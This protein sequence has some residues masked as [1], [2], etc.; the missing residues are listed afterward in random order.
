MVTK[1][2]PFLQ[3][4]HTLSHTHFIIIVITTQIKVID[5]ERLQISQV[6]S[7]DWVHYFMTML[8]P[9]LL[10]FQSSSSFILWP[11]KGLNAFPCVYQGLDICVYLQC[12]PW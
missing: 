11:N 8:I 9:L 5:E 6:I 1:D 7:Y 2:F 10:K 4:L 12:A 3:I